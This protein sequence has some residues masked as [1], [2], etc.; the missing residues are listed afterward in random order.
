MSDYLG[1]LIRS[2][3]FGAAP[4]V[5]LPAP[6]PVDDDPLEQA[7]PSEAAAH[8]C[9]DTPRPNVDPAPSGAAAGARVAAIDAADL[10]DSHRGTGHPAPAATNAQ[11]RVESPGGPD[12]SPPATA[13]ASAPPA[14]AS[15]TGAAPHPVVQAALRW[16]A[17]DPALRRVPTRAEAPQAADATPGFHGPGSDATARFMPDASEAMRSAPSSPIVSAPGPA[18]PAASPSGHRPRAVDGD[19]HAAEPYEA[20]PVRFATAA[21]ALPAT[22]PAESKPAPE[23][24]IGSIHVTVDAPRPPAAPPV[25]APARPTSAARGAAPRSAYLRSRA[26]RI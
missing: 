15:V 17:A 21:R 3:G 24:H 19:W 2:A 1:A 14:N 22:P 12:P 7:V 4:L 25:P 9:A 26:P 5:G 11:S 13:S 20:A 16:V 10:A 18:A 8:A 23:V 6:Q